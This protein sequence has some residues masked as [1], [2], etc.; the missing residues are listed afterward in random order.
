LETRAYLLLARV[1]NLPTVWKNVLAAYVVAGASRESLAVAS[2][3]LSLFYVAGMFLNDAFDAAFDAAVR[4]DRPIPA[5]DVSRTE[6]FAVGAALMAAGALLLAWLPYRLPALM[7][8][9]ALGAAILFYDYQH[10][11]RS[12]GPVVMGACRAL[13]Y[14]TAAAGATGRVSAAV[15][16]SAVVMWIYIIVLTRVAKTPGYVSTVPYLLAGICV[17]D[18]AMIAAAGAPQLAMVA[19]TG[20]ITTLAFQRVVPGT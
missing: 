10:K 13:V 19:A 15:A 7:W 18:A 6:V 8:G 1:S 2:I 16:T 12:F 17:V 11:G 5:G 20:Y 9:A 4:A 3:A 14:A